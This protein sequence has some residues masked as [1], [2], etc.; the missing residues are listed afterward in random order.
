MTNFRE[1]QDPPLR[2]CLL[3]MTWFSVVFRKNT[4][5]G[6]RSLVG[7]AMALPCNGNRVSTTAVIARPQA[8]AISW[9]HSSNRAAGKDIVP[10]DSHGC[11][12]SL[13]MTWF[14]V[15]F[16]NNEPG[17]Y[18]HLVGKAIALPYSIYPSD[19]TRRGDPCGRPI[20]GK[21]KTLPYGIAAPQLPCIR[22]FES[23]CK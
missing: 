7:K 19:T 9:Y 6:H 23:H 3:G 5:R 17:D 11:Y 4:P 1:G 16:R 14:S 2:I 10:G 20:L 12:R 13:G 18:R 8:V 21:V 15:V 22:P